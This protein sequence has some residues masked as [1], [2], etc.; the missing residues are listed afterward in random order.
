MRAPAPWPSMPA[1]CVLPSAGARSPAMTLSMVDLPQPDG[2]TMET[3]SPSLTARLTRSRARVAP[4]AMLRPETET[5]CGTARPLLVPEMLELGRHHLVVGDVCLHRADLFLELVAEAHGLLGDGGR[6]GILL[7]GDDGA[8]H[9]GIHGREDLLADGH[10]GLGILAHALEGLHHGPDHALGELR[11]GGQPL[12]ARLQGGEGHVLEKLRP[13][14]EARVDEV[15]RQLEL[16]HR[17]GA[18]RLAAHVAV[19]LA[20]LE[21]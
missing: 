12:V 17:D 15:A 2:P 4:N 6:V 8:D 5:F 1:T 16:L 13:L 19:D 7:D 10:R 18:G 14:P 20:R 9:R 3:N 11:I 21:G